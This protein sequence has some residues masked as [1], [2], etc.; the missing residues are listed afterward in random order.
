MND[1]EDI[2]RVFRPLIKFWW[3]ILIGGLMGLGKGYQKF[4]TALPSY[5]ARASIKVNDQFTEASKFMEELENFSYVGDKLDVL[6]LIRS[7]YM[8]SRAIDSLDIDVYYYVHEREN[9]HNLYPRPPFKLDYTLHYSEYRD[10]V[11]ELEYI[12]D[13]SLLIKDPITEVI[14]I[15]LKWGETYQT[16][17]YT[18]TLCKTN[19]ARSG[20]RPGSYGFMI[21][22]KEGLIEDLGNMDDLLVRL[23]YEKASIINMYAWHDAPELAADFSNALTNAYISHY[24]EKKLSDARQTLRSIDEELLLREQEL[25]KAEEEMAKF[26]TQTMVWDLGTEAFSN[27]ELRAEMGIMRLNLEMKYQDL[28][29]LLKAVQ[30]DTLVD[31]IALNY[32]AIG[33]G[34][35]MDALKEL[36]FL[37]RSKKQLV[38]YYVPDHPKILTHNRKLV[39]IKGSIIR[40]TKK[41]L[42]SNVAQMHTIDQAMEVM[43]KRYETLPEKEEKLGQLKREVERR[44]NAFVILLEKRIEAAISSAA[45]FHYHKILEVGYAPADPI[46]PLKHVHLG[47]NALMGVLYTIAFIFIVRFLLNVLTIESDITELSDIPLLG[48]VTQPPVSS[49]NILPDFVGLATEL[50][51]DPAIRM[52]GVTAWKKGD[53][54]RPSALHLAKAAAS[55]GINTLL[56]DSHRDASFFV[57]QL[58]LTHSQGMQQSLSKKIAIESFIQPSKFP[59]LSVLL[60]GNAGPQGE[61]SPIFHPQMMPSIQSLKTKYDL[62][63]LTLPFLKEEKTAITWIKP[64]DLTLVVGKILGT[65]PGH[66]KKAEALLVEHN[67]P[68][69]YYWLVRRKFI[70]L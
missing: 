30:Q 39:N 15:P 38:K 57:E 20:F 12:S 60:S 66:V 47:V 42:M 22:S 41:T 1:A 8:I 67:I 17:A 64:C 48:S 6:A 65:R 14:S 45:D 51:L 13:D 37:V 31:E 7:K 53:G 2:R 52:V 61:I 55:A 23:Q 69:T 36:N 32:K 54:K 4:N 58:G 50:H 44:K 33:D 25:F 10:Q 35:F 9:M 29:N 28:R 11:F 5:Q 19:H 46:K 18:F 24:L 27:L 16:N 56:I 43:K 40:R 59:L 63:I 49:D 68:N 3:F 26:E 21:N 34:V 70:R 62:I